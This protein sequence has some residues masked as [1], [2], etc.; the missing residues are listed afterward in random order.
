MVESRS[1][2]ESRRTTAWTAAVRSRLHVAVSPSKWLAGAMT[3]SI[4]RRGRTPILLV[5]ALGIMTSCSHEGPEGGAAVTTPSTT[6]TDRPTTTT[7]TN[8]TAAAEAEVDAAYRAASRAFVDAAAIPDP[9]FEALAATHVGPMFEQRRGV[10]LALQADGRV[11][12]YAT[13]SQYRIDVTDVTI[14]GDIARLDVCGVDDGETVVV[15]TG[16]VIL[17]GLGTVRARAAMRRVDGVWKLAERT[18]EDE[19]EGIAGCAVE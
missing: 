12:R 2:F 10:L 4:A 19:W 7:T 17:G 18:K 5:V 3:R 14:D 9:N 16:E 13:N 6:T 15:P 11:I 8:P 1:A